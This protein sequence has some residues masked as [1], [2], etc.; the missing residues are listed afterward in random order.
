MIAPTPGVGDTCTHPRGVDVL[1]VD[2]PPLPHDGRTEMLGITY[3]RTIDAALDEI[4]RRDRERQAALDAL[5]SLTR[6][7]PDLEGDLDLTVAR[8][9]LQR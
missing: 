5:N 1:R 2:A 7:H 6:R 9:A 8:L 4:S 3:A